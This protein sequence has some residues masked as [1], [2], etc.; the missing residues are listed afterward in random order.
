MLK[1]LNRHL[2]FLMTLSSPVVAQDFQKGLLLTV[3]VT[4]L[5]LFKSG[6]L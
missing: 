2:A 3:L 1:H 4:M 5:R 6:S